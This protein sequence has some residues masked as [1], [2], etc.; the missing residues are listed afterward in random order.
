MVAIVAMVTIAA[1]V[2]FLAMTEMQSFV[3]I[4]VMVATLAFVA[5]KVAFAAKKTIV[6]TEAMKL[7]ISEG[8]ECWRALRTCGHTFTKDVKINYNLIIFDY[9]MKMRIPCEE[10]Y[11]STLIEKKLSSQISHSHTSILYQG[12]QYSLTCFSRDDKTFYYLIKK[13]QTFVKDGRAEKK[14]VNFDLIYMSRNFGCDYFSFDDYCIN[15]IDQVTFT[16]SPHS[17]FKCKICNDYNK[18]DHININIKIY[19]DA[20]NPLCSIC[21]ENE[22]KMAFVPCGHFH[23]C[24]ECTQQMTSC[25]LCKHP[26][27][28]VVDLSTTRQT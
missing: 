25:P 27:T 23:T 1:I 22:K 14:W 26:Y 28:C 10:S 21:R 6:P 20:D 7:E 15:Y 8:S 19:E 16:K 5:E 3:A 12:T 17:N 24:Y 4:T 13:C 18:I 9:F 2:A 11:L